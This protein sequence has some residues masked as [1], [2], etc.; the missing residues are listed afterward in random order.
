MS[1]NQTIYLKKDPLH[2]PKEGL[3]FPQQVFRLHC[4]IQMKST[5]YTSI[6]IT[7]IF[8]MELCQKIL[9]DPTYFIISN[10]VSLSGYKEKT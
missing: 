2:Y 4:S 5:L 7:N 9:L 8:H 1:T 3:P 6:N 10:N